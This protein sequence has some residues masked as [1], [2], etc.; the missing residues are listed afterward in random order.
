MGHR[1]SDNNTYG[2]TSGI[3]NVWRVNDG[4][5]WRSFESK[6]GFSAV[7]MTF[8]T[9]GVLKV[10]FQEFYDVELNTWDIRSG[11][12]LGQITQLP[13]IDR[14]DRLVRLHPDGNTYFVRGD[15][16]GTRIGNI[17]SQSY[18]ELGIYADIARFS[19]RGQ[20][21]AIATQEEVKLFVTNRN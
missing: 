11:E 19:P 6:K 5:R 21:L 15:V 17:R 13:T 4:K 20:L 12:L 14:Q 9:K 16:A 1:F 18:S 2:A 8:T 3:V 10:L 7:A